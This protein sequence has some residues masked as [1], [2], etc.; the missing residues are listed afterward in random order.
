MIRPLSDEEKAANWR[1]AGRYF[2]AYFILLLIPG[3]IILWAAGYGHGY[4]DG[5][6]AAFLTTRKDS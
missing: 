2:R 6:Q 1:V 5:M 3:L 4:L